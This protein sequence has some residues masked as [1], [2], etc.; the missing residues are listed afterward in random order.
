MQTIR[1]RR[2]HCRKCTGEFPRFCP[3][4]LGRAEGHCVVWCAACPCKREPVVIV[5]VVQGTNVNFCIY[6]GEQQSHTDFLYV[7][8]VW[9]IAL[10]LCDVLAG[11]QVC[12]ILFPRL[13]QLP[14]YLD[15]ARLSFLGLS[16]EP[17]RG[18][19]GGVG[20]PCGQLSLWFLPLCKNTTFHPTQ[21]KRVALHC[22]VWA[23]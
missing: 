14:G 1:K 23:L 18:F 22:S 2:V 6:A 19:R 15:F 5:P 9:V 12:G 7:P 16:S 11:R 4:G 8:L 13:P 21:Q 10:M 17:L 20:R 3:V